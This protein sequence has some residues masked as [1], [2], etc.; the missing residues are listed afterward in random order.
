[1]K[2]IKLIDSASQTFS[3]VLN[4]KRCAFAF[5]Y[6]PTSDRWCFDLAVADVWKARGRRVVLGRDLLATQD[7]GIGALVAIDFEDAGNEPNRANLPAR[8]VRLYQIDPDEEGGG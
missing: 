6:N 5:R 4:G 1:M 2:E 3:V 8:R 7:P